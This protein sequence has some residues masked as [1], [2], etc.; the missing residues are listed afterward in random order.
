VK[1]EV[2]CGANR[3]AEAKLLLQVVEL[4]ASVH[5]T[6]IVA[7]SARL[8]PGVHV[9]AYS[10][11]GAHVEIGEGTIVGDHVVIDGPTKIGA[12]NH[13]FPYCSVGLPRRT[14]STTASPRPSRWATATWCAS[15]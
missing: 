8:G 10:I 15:S 9:G 2:R 11:V 13:F 7:P 14:S 5:P 6:A 3:V 12:G 1:G 4:R